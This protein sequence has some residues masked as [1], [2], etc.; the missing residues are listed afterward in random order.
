MKKDIKL[1]R[2]HCA[3]CAVNLE[4]KVKEVDG[5]LNASVDFVK[6]IVSIEVENKNADKIIEDVENT[7]TKFD[8]SIKIVDTSN[9]EKEAKKEKIE[10]IFDITKIF[11]ALALGVAA[12]FIPLYWLKVT[13]FVVAYLAVGIQV[14]YTAI[15]NIF[16]GKVLDENFLMSVA[17]I[18]A[19]VLG[20]FIEAIAVMLL[21]SVG[22]MFEDY[23]VSKSRRRISSLMEIKS[24]SANLIDGQ[25]ER[26]VLVGEVKVGDKIRIKPGEKVPLDCVVLE[27]NSSLSTA[28]ITGESKE[29]F[30][31]KGSELLSGYINGEGV[32]VCKVTK[33]EKDS[34]ITKI[35]N[36]VEN[37]TKS[38]AQTEKFISKF[39]KWYTPIVVC[40]AVLLATLPLA[41]GG[42][43]S[44]WI[45]RALTFLVASCPCALVI[46]IPLC[47]FAGIG[48]SARNGVL[49]KGSTY[50]EMLAKVDTVVFDKTGTL[51]HGNFTVSKIHAEPNTTE[52]EV[53]ELI[54]YAE[55]FSN[56]RIA[57]S[58]VK[59]YGK[60]INTA[61]VQDYK[62]IAGRGI[63]VTL[64]MEP[65][66]VGNARLMKEHGIEFCEADEAGTAVYLAKNGECMGYCLI[67]DEIKADSIDGI[68]AIE[69]MGINVAMFTGD[70]DKVAS[71]VAKNL[72]IEKYYASLLPEGKVEKLKELKETQS[73]LAFVGDGIND[74]PVLASVDVGISMGGVGS[75]I[76]IEAS[77]VVIMTDQ[78]SKIAESI[79]IAKKTSRL[80]T[81]NIIFIM[82]IKVA[83]LVLTAI[84]IS[85]MWLAV[86]AD[87][88]VSC[89]AI[90]N[91]MRIMLHKNKSDTK[92]LKIKQK[93]DNINK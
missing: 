79:K 2:I 11:V 91:S 13:L 59:R 12:Y 85:E 26:L 44:V 6:R 83:V 80:I 29:F 18:G 47:Y 36:M 1:T 51:T 23:A 28:V 53:L 57:K 46:S 87:V 63:E 86:F 32:L 71:K 21:Y 54:A 38:K 37:A 56:H 88:G 20:E 24:E 70:N 41:F 4:D 14:L 10:K 68:K 7:I 25:E 72:G 73:H 84:G 27:G 92:H 49:V 65:C 93:D 43:F 17:T 60:E 61:W 42:V 58:I 48:V 52:D 16:R 74:A 75:D 5:V 50:L 69:N 8:S 77:D 81:E 22:E 64:F 33:S 78:P 39:A 55:S 40:V 90:L 67:E 66:L 30:A 45:Y 31:E 62:E 19:L 89:L 34:T 35:V 76:A 15:R 9:E 82:L 3:G